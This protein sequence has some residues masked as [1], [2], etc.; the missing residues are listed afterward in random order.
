[1]KNY[2]PFLVSIEL[3]FDSSEYQYKSY[4]TRGDVLNVTLIK[5]D[6]ITTCKNEENF[7]FSGSNVWV[8]QGCSGKFIVTLR[9]KPAF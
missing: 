6:S 3:Q 5:Q 4:T 1:M 8:D 7:G 9:G 2:L